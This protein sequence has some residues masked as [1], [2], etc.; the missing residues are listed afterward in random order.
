[1]RALG[2]TNP[3]RW[4]LEPEMPT[5]QE[6]GVADYDLPSFSAVMGPA[7]ISAE[8]V[9]RMNTAIN[10]GLKDPV[11]VQRLAANGTIAFPSSPTEFQ[12]LMRSQRDKWRELVRISGVQPE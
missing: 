12:S 11:L 6:Q 4:P 2:I 10:Q 3:T 7:G 8:I 9:Q 5:V 1:V